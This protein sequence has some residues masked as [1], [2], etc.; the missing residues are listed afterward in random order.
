M[1]GLRAVHGLQQ[2]LQ[3][4]DSGALLGNTGLFTLVGVL[5]P[6]DQFGGQLVFELFQ[7][8]VGIFGLFVDGDTHAQ[9]K[10]GVILKQRVVP[11][12]SPSIWIN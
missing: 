5:Q 2:R 10:L 3:L 6:F 4:G 12:R 8:F 11:G 9:T 1:P 7:Q